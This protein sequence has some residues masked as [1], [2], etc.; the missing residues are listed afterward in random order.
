[1]TKSWNS[2]GGLQILKLWTNVPNWSYHLFKSASSWQLNPYL[3][4]LEGRSILQ[5]F[6]QKP[7]FL[8]SRQRWQYLQSRCTSHGKHRLQYLQSLHRLTQLTQHSFPFSLLHG[9][10]LSHSG[11]HC[12]MDKPEKARRQN[13][14]K[15]NIVEGTVQ[16]HT[17]AEGASLFLYKYEEKGSKKC[18]FWVG[19]CLP[20]CCC[21]FHWIFGKY[22]VKKIFTGG[23]IGDRP[24]LIIFSFPSFFFFGTFP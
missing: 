15:R 1:M 18:L 12:I 9:S 23:W 7:S 8:H 17:L 6:P 24:K 2:E 13:W 14:R 16:I 4:C 5:T 22:V 3:G 19:G 21:C 11:N 10:H 20:F